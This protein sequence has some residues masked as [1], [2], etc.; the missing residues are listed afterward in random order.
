MR[1]RTGQ[2]DGEDMAIMQRREP[3][4]E[5]IADVFFFCTIL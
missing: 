1:V 4:R 2:S 3:G 5:D